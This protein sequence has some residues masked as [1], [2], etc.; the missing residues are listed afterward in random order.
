MAARSIE[1]FC[2]REDE[3]DLELR[4]LAGDEAGSS[5][6]E[7]RHDGETIGFMEMDAELT[8]AYRLALQSIE[9]RAKESA[10]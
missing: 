9:Q 2:V 10:K 4:T 5:K 8:R 3:I 1:A 6:I 7:V